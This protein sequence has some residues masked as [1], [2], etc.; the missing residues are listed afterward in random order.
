MVEVVVMLGFSVCVLCMG[1]CFL[2]LFEWMV[3]F[4][5]YRGIDVC[6]VVSVYVVLL[7][8]EGVLFVCYFVCV[9]MLFWCEDCLELVIY[10]CSVLVCC[11]L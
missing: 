6:D 3:M 10:L 11:V 1:W 9:L 7:F 5:L 8:D 2:E 4:C